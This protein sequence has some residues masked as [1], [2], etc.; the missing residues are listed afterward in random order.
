[1]SH[2]EDLSQETLIQDT[3]EVL[4]FV[5]SEFPEDNII[6]VGHSMGGSIATK[7]CEYILKNKAQYQELYDKIQGLICIDVVEGT[8]ME[9]LPYM[10]SIVENRPQY[11]SSIN[12]G[13]EYMF[14]NGTIKNL[15]SAKISVPSLLKEEEKNGNTIYSWKTDLM[16]SQKYWTEWF[17]GLTKAFLS[18]KIPKILMLAGIERMDKDL[19][20]AQMQGQFQLSVVN[21]VGHIIHED[22]PVKVMKIFEDFVHTFKITGKL[23][24]MKPI[25]GK[26]GG[27]VV[28]ME[29]IKYKEFVKP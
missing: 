20:I 22:D 18:C 23:S 25:I 6:V 1:M 16:A 11:F 4:N 26:L 15:E 12:K 24:E 29:T 10:E 3:I 13:I 5:S 28:T 27:A 8:A 17:S 14:K 19:V 9:A 21:D 7:T 2:G